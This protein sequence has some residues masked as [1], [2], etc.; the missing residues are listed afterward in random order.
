MVSEEERIVDLLNHF[1]DVYVPMVSH[2]LQS[3]SVFLQ[4]LRNLFAMANL[5]DPK[6]L[7]REFT[8]SQGFINAPFFNQRRS[9]SVKVLDLV[10]WER[11]EAALQA[12]LTF[13]SRQC[14]ILVSVDKQDEDN[15]CCHF[16]EFWKDG[17]KTI[18]EDKLDSLNDLY[19][20]RTLV[21]TK[22]FA[23]GKSDYVLLYSFLRLDFYVEF[24]FRQVKAAKN[25]DEKSHLKRLYLELFQFVFGRLREI[26]CQ[27]QSLSERLSDTP[28]AIFV[29][30][31]TGV[32]KS[33]ILNL[34]NKTPCFTVSNDDMSSKTFL[35]QAFSKRDFIYVDLPG[36]KDT[37]DREIAL[38]NSIMLSSLYRSF[39]KS[40]TVLTF[41]FNAFQ[42]S[43]RGSEIRHVYDFLKT[44][45]VCKEA[46]VGNDD[47]ELD[48]ISDE[49]SCLEIP[50]KIKKSIV[51][52]INRYDGNREKLDEL[53]SRLHQK[54]G[55]DEDKMIAI[56]KSTDENSDTIKE[57]RRALK[58]IIKETEST[59]MMDEDEQACQK[60]EAQFQVVVLEE[61]KSIM[62]EYRQYVLESML[63][64]APDT[65]IQWHKTIKDL[66]RY[67]I[68]E[69]L[70]E[71]AKKFVGIVV[72]MI[73]KNDGLRE[74]LFQIENVKEVFDSRDTVEKKT[75]R[76][77]ALKKALDE[78]TKQKN[79]LERRSNNMEPT[80]SEPLKSMSLRPIF[81]TKSNIKILEAEIASNHM[82]NKGKSSAEAWIK[83]AMSNPSGV[84]KYHKNYKLLHV[85]AQY[86]LLNKAIDVKI[87]SGAATMA[88]MLQDCETADKHNPFH[89]AALYGSSV[90]FEQY[91]EVLWEASNDREDFLKRFVSMIERID[92]T[93]NSV[94]HLAA[95]GR[96]VEIIQLIF[97]FLT[98]SDLPGELGKRW[99]EKRK[100]LCLR[101]G[102]SRPKYYPLHKLCERDC[103]TDEEKE[104]VRKCMKMLLDHG[105]IKSLLA[106]PGD[107]ATSKTVLCYACERISDQFVELLI[108]YLKQ[109]Q[110]SDR[111]RDIVNHDTREGN[112]RSNTPLYYTFKK[113]RPDSIEIQRAK[114]IARLLVK[115]GAD[116]ELA[117]RKNKTKM[118]DLG[119]KNGYL[120][121]DE[122]HE[123]A[124]ISRK[125]GNLV[126]DESLQQNMR[127]RRQDSD[128]GTRTHRSNRQRKAA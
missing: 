117:V 35:P 116:V 50:E 70:D 34:M 107:E 122:V 29:L 42:T 81:S 33:H 8:G 86:N 6:P 3:K 83:K 19:N 77:E 96:Q 9:D 24:L 120:T 52:V 49:I 103:I 106:D 13:F 40:V 99:A 28:T 26:D 27:A 109:S 125:R 100:E 69:G 76:L 51:V 5:G 82:I 32:G 22:Q 39:P 123:L 18:V 46:N 111:I 108:E 37:R 55:I 38:L 68:F 90:V 58:R 93:R 17:R 41:D 67:T 45:F 21:L 14:N 16:F 101:T 104:R 65:I 54:F 4:S 127:R 98:P 74:S 89:V 112:E 66:Y 87:K 75:E 10:D 7:L 124:D 126:R 92:R 73:E 12:A 59:D 48:D 95:Q 11:D 115:N 1:E 113:T 15:N 110:A 62:P 64:E 118:L 97:K 105:S 53:R 119:Q 72:A 31:I 57:E 71:F 80:I 44:F 47:D 25:K 63:D 60:H 91:V 36:I 23:D 20:N 61:F 84:Q 88:Q 43:G 102:S 85:I 128:A 30:G 78:N 94:L 114:N 79:R 2:S 56:S 121:S